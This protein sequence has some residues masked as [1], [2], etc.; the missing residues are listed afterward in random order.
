MP[1]I[2][3]E[4]VSKYY[5]CEKRSVP[6]LCDV[7][8]TINQGEFVFVTGSS[9][10]GKSTLLQL[11]AR[12]IIPTKGNIY[13]DKMNITHLAPWNQHRVQ[14]LFGY[15]PQFPQLVRKRTIE[16]NLEMAAILTQKHFGPSMQERIQKALAIVGMEDVSQKY[17]VELSVGECRRVELARAV[18]NNPSILLL[19]ELTANL[20]EDTS[21]D[22]MHFLNELNVQGTTIIMATHA[23]TMV[24]L[25]RKRVITIVDGRILGDVPKGRYGDIRSAPTHPIYVV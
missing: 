10:A 15:V 25:M 20:D 19:D 4:K 12:Q 16:Q 9:G 2:R 22:I 5:Q 7:D 14:M 13:L 21:W 1:Q 6:S 11:I 17:P 24:N 23:K 3:L 18:I 8:L